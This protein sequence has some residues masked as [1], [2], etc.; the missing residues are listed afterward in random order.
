ML[1][2]AVTTSNIRIKNSTYLIEKYAELK[3]NIL[4]WEK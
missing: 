2:V 1:F 3:N 4:A